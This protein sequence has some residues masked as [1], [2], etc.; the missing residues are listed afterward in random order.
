MSRIKLATGIKTY[1]IENENGEILGVIKFNPSDVNLYKR[2][3]QFEK[4]AE[5]IEAELNECLENNDEDTLKVAMVKAD[6]KFKQSIDDMLGKGTSEIVFGK[7]NVFNTLDGVTFLE[8]F[9][10]AIIPII[11]ADIEASS[12]AKEQKISKYTGVVEALGDK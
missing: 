5:E 11:K 10:I 2:V 1:E 7:Q 3:E 8:R 9:L 4:D 12:K 6:A